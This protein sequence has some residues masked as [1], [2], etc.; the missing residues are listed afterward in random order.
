M[1]INWKKLKQ[2]NNTR[3]IFTFSEQQ[4]KDVTVGN[5][6]KSAVFPSQVHLGQIE[7]QWSDTMGSSTEMETLNLKTA[8]NRERNKGTETMTGD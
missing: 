8:A 6:K 3:S 5:K 1:G 2:G 7:M 4:N